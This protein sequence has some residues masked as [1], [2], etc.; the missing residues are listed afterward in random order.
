MQE[1]EKEKGGENVRPNAHFVLT[2][3]GWEMQKE[4]NVFPITDNRKL[5]QQKRLENNDQLG[6]WSVVPAARPQ[7][8]PTTTI[9]RK[10]SR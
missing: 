3:D 1:N 6:A 9:K 8:S 2:F 10:D 5:T 4:E 7:S